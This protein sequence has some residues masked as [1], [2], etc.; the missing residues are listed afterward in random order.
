M[1]RSSPPTRALLNIERLQGWSMLVYYPLEHLYYLRTHNI[2]PATIPSLFHR[3]GKTTNLHVSKLA[4]WSCRAWAVYVLLQF[5]HLVEDR[6]LLLRRE[7]HIKKGKDVSAEEQ[8]DLR[9]G[10]DAFWNELVS[11]TANL[12]LAIHWW[13]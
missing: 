1:E 4:M 11:N 2:I 3:S 9:R 7:K 12:P 13:V 10:W 5:V 8:E 6:K